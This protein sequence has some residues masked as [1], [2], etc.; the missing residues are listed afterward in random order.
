MVEIAKFGFV[1]AF[2]AI[3][4]LGYFLKL[5]NIV[6]IESASV[7]SRIVL[8]LFLPATIFSAFANVKIDFEPLYFLFFGMGSFMAF[9]GYLAGYIVTKMIT[10]PL[11]TQ[12]TLIIACGAMNIGL[13]AF[14]FFIA[15]LGL[16]GLVY[17][18]VF[19]IGQA[20]FIYFIAVLI[21]KEYSRRAD[22][23]EMKSAASS[24]MKRFIA[25][26]L[27]WSI[28]CGLS[29]NLLGLRIIYSAFEPL[30]TL[31]SSA[32]VPLILILLGIFVEPKIEKGKAI[33]LVIFVRFVLSFLIAFLF[34]LLTGITGLARLTIFAVSV[35]PSAI[36]TLVY[37]NE[38]GL[39]SKFAASVVS[40]TILIG[41][42]VTSSIF[43]FLS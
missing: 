41:I 9:I 19:D 7:L 34:V 25:N 2:L 3:I 43:I 22:I 1:F 16:D 23:E 37:S 42:F 36:L 10:L 27:I 32:T 20:P 30:L 39:D 24:G 29:V 13:F 5:K 4:G 6:R 12:G 8:Y 40:I 33:L 15:F 17:A 28:I 38:E 11:R 31:I 14:P 21:A 18:V 26:P 35:V